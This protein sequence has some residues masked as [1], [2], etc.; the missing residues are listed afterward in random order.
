MCLPHPNRFLPKSTHA[1][2]RVGNLPRDIPLLVVVVHAQPRRPAR[3]SR[4]QRV[5]PLRKRNFREFMNVDER[6]EQP[7][8]WKHTWTGVLP[9]SRPFF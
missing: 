5:V 4:V 1:I 6:V 9:L 8:G 7:I 3:E 2:S